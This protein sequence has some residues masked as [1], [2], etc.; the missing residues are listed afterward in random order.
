MS[1]GTPMAEQTAK[2]IA[3]AIVA[4]LEDDELVSN[5]ATFPRLTLARAYLALARQLAEA[6]RQNERLREA[7]SDPMEEWSFGTLVYIARLLLGHNYPADI[8]DGS[9]GDPGP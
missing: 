9:S 1:T 7:L 2:G 8:F 4:E 5:G 6:E 3:E